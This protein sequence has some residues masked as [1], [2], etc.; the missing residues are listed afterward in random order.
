MN[1]AEMFGIATA[2]VARAAVDHTLPPD[3]RKL[4]E[5]GQ[6][7]LL[8][9]QLVGNAVAPVFGPPAAVDPGL[10][11]EVTSVDEAASR[12]DCHSPLASNFRRSFVGIV[13]GITQC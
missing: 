7:R 5:L 2:A 6:H 3:V 1:A 12:R 11:V 4:L 8:S 13:C 10:H 9:R